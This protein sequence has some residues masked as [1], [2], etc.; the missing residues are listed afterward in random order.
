VLGIDDR[1]F[2]GIDAAASLKPA[3][4]YHK[5]FNDGKVFRGID[6]AASLKRDV[7]RWCICVERRVFRG[8]DAAASLK[9]QSS[10]QWAQSTA[11][12][13]SSSA[14]SMPRPH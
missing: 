10:T 1:V 12:A 11:R 13:P 8:I 4:A 3:D 14:A 5:A 6:A 2:R 9:R 7:W